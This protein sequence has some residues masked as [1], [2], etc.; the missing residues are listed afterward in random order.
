MII[1]VDV[2]AL[3]C[4]IAMQLMRTQYATTMYDYDEDNNIWIMKA[5]YVPEYEEICIEIRE[6]L[7][8]YHSISPSYE[9]FT[10]GVF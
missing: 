5:S 8:A 3:A 6:Y 7:L 4:D 9:K 2:D 1:N 10:I